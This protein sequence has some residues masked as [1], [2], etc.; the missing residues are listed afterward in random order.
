MAICLCSLSFSLYQGPQ[1][2]VQ[3]TQK[4]AAI[5]VLDMCIACEV[6]VHVHIT[7]HLHVGTG[8]LCQHNANI[9]WPG[10]GTHKNSCTQRKSCPYTH[11]IGFVHT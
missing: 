8:T 6:H 5:R 1:P 10:A 11:W 9:Q 4:T 3:G 7:L 2:K